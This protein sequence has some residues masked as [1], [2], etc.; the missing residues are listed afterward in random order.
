MENKEGPTISVPHLDPDVESDFM[1]T[2]SIRQME[3]DEL[4]EEEMMAANPAEYY[5]Q[6]CE[7]QE[8]RISVLLERVYAEK[9][10]PEPSFTIAEMVD[11]VKANFTKTAGNEFCNMYFALARK[12]GMLSDETISQLIIGIPTAIIERDKPH[13]TIEMPNVQQFNNNPQTVNN[14]GDKD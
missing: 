13:Q 11:Y 5:K 10:K 9:P 2:A 7:E 14:Y 12:H 3:E 4:R 6:R 1:F 8:K